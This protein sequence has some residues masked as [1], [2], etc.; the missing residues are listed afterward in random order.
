MTNLGKQLVYKSNF[1]SLQFYILLCHL[2]IFSQ[3]SLIFFCSENVLCFKSAAYIQ[4]HF[5]LDFIME[6]NTMNP[7]QT[8]AKGAV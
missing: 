7:D 5:S 1:N 6:E 8:T 3:T 2:L 4:V